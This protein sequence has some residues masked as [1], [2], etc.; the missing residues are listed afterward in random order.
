MYSFQFFFINLDM[1][2]NYELQQIICIS[3]KPHPI[4]FSSQEEI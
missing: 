2:S 1:V 3:A 4:W